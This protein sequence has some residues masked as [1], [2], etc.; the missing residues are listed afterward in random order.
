M[1]GRYTITAL[2]P[3]L[4]ERFKALFSYQGFKPRFN[5]APSQVLPVILNEDPTHIVPALWGYIPPWE[6]DPDEATGSINARAE[7]AMS[8]P[9][10][11]SSFIQ[12]RCLILA[13]GFFEWKSI[14]RQ[15]KVPYWIS[16][17]NQAP[18]AFAGLWSKVHHRLHGD[19]ISFAILTTEPNF[20]VSKV[21]DRMPV[22]LLPRDEKNYLTAPP[23]TAAQLL[24]PYPDDLLTARPVSTLVNSPRNDV[25]EVLSSL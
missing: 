1:C 11:R 15:K 10:F 25:P 3:V 5:A 12:R 19:F 24:R 6:K 9:Y 23:E 2:A 8:K 13:D 18:I 21:H 22:I 17:K 16:L 14:T 7:T 20:F 4:E